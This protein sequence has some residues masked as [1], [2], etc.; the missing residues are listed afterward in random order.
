MTTS[1]NWDQYTGNITWLKDRTIFLTVHG[2]RAYGTSIPTSDTDIR[3]IC[4]APKEY[5]LGCSSVCEQVEQ[6]D[7]D[8]TVFELRKFFKLAM[9]ANPN[10]LELLFTE[11]EDHLWVT[12]L[13]KK[14]LDNREL[15]LS[16][17]AKFTFQGYAHSQMKRISGHRGFLLHPVEEP[18]TRAS[19]GLPDRTV[20]PADQLAAANSAIKKRIDEWSWHELEGTDPATRQALQEEF[21]RRLTE[22]TQWNETQVD[23]GVHMA[24]C[25]SLGFDTNF[26]ELLDRERL[27]GNKMREYSQYQE[28]KRNRN[29]ARAEMEAKFGFDLKHALHLVRLSRSCKE[30]LLTGKLNVRRPDAEELLSIRQGAWT[31]DQLMGWFKQQ[32]IEIEEAYQKSTLPHSPDRKKLDQLCVEM[33]EEALSQRAP[34]VD[35]II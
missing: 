2:S 29:P 12:P 20:I 33:V 3:G 7:P 13:G 6:K 18:P 11:P 35:G 16:K 25:K 1:W 26:L 14:L 34:I 10:V 5:Y 22:I 30:L 8:L 28:W 21:T 32:E 15:L 27:Y 23:Q 31:Y 17:R 9:D 24:A 19:C 4:I